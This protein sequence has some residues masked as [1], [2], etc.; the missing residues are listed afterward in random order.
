MKTKPFK[1]D[2]FFDNE[3][4]MSLKEIDAKQV[5]FNPVTREIFIDYDDIIELTKVVKTK[6]IKAKSTGKIKRTIKKPNKKRTP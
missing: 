5:R 1:P 2:A 6:P 3:Q 4:V